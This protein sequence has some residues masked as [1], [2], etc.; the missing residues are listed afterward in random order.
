MGSGR[1]RP[2]HHPARLQGLRRE[3]PL[4]VDIV[5]HFII[6]SYVKIFMAAAFGAQNKC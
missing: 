3:P 4:S 1:T 5:E 6:D 2:Q